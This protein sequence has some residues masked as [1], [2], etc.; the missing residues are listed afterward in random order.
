MIAAL[1]CGFVNAVYSFASSNQLVDYF[2]EKISR[3]LSIIILNDLHCP[4]QYLMF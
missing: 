4:I 3:L 2:V 1:F